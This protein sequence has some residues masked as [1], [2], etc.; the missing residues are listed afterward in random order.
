[1][2]MKSNDP[3]FI[4]TGDQQ[5][6]TF[7]RPATQFRIRFLLWIIALCISIIIARVFFLQIVFG[8]DYRRTAEGNRIQTHVVK[9]LRGVIYDAKGELLVKN[10]PNFSLTINAQQALN[11]KKEA[12]EQLANTLAHI[13][14]LSPADIVN[15]FDQAKRSGQNVV[16]KDHIPYTDAL[17][18]MI[19]IQ[20]LPAISVEPFYSRQYLGGEPYAHLLGYT[21]KI[22]ETE[23]ANLKD[24]GY[25]LTDEIGK[26]GVEK[27]YEQ[28]LRGKDGEQDIE[29]DFRGAQQSV[30]ADVAP[31]SG[32]AVYLSIEPTLQRLLYE[33]IKTAVDEQ[34]LP[35]GSAVA[36][37]PRDGRVLALVSYPSYDNNTFAQGISQDAYDAL[38]NDERHPLF[39]RSIAGQYPS[40][41]TFKPIVAAA[42]LEEGVVT[43]QT[44]IVSTGGLQIDIYRFPDWKPGG[45]GVTDLNKAMAESVN[46]YFYLLGGGDNKTSTG[47]GVE[48]ITAYARRFG[49]GEQVGIDVPGE[50]S[51]FLPTKQWKEEFKNEQWYIGDTYHY[52]IG[53]GDLLVTPLQ[54][55]TYTAIIANGGTFYQPHVVEKLV[56]EADG[57]TRIIDPIISDPQVVSKPTIEA[58]RLAM[59]EDV[60]SPTGSGRTLQ[61][62]PVSSAGKTGTAQTYGDEPTHSWFTVFAPYET[63]EIALTV[64]VEKAGHGY[65]A[66]VPIARE[67]LQ[68]YFV[69]R[70]PQ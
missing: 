50:A 65:G 27:S 67:V 35:G 34:H 47:L 23:Y 60:L 14:Q 46:T 68:E 30:V 17:Q 38:Q 48:R 59:R 25:L 52:A 2:S 1:M 69:N 31:Q 16:L 37:D 33:K 41:S 15:A 56:S 19:A 29:V 44:T 64:L 43:P 32:D 8:S 61:S 39:H 45:H 66:A 13:A 55:A 53:Q 62:L 36:I 10:I 22:S 40:G 49:L 24:N 70:I 51:G 6:M 20:Q 54:V 57:S 3:F 11:I 63:P 7:N 18:D 28:A 4:D 42:G 26:S 5:Q 21:A 58:V 9:A 12:R